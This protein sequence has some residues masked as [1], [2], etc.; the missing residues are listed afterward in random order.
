[1]SDK[2]PQPAIGSLPQIEGRES[3]AEEVIRILRRA[4][5]T[6]VFAD[7]ERL[8][9]SQIAGQ[10]GTSIM[11]V[12]EA[13]VALTNEGLVASEPNK[14][15]RA[16]PLDRQDLDD[17]YAL[18]AHISGLLAHRAAVV[19][20]ADELAV[21]RTIHEEFEQ[22]ARGLDL[23]VSHRVLEELNDKF[24][25]YLNGIADGARLRWFLRLT[26][27]LM[28]YVNVHGWCG[29]ALTDHPK[30]IAALE[31]RD[32][33]LAASLVESHFRLGIDLLHRD[34]QGA[35]GIEVPAEGG[36]RP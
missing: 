13:L 25:R 31:A 17:V 23:T 29:A 6:G 19:I 21:L 12:R 22:A 32:A 1:M 3:I 28:G 26:S 4:I 8:N 9:L 20:A 14:G 7:R 5:L 16:T 24:H 36:T 15:F 2:R 11:P 34:S 30:I 33:V 27:R 35:G 10:L 18:H